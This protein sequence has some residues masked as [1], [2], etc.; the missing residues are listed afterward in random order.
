VGNRLALHSTSIGKA[1]LA[2]LLPA[3][4]ATLLAPEAL[5]RRTARTLT[6]VRELEAELAAIRGQGYAIDDEENEEQIRCVGAAI[7][8]RRGHVI[9]G[10]SLSAPAFAMPVTMAHLLGPSVLA[11]ARELSI[12]LGARQDVLPAPY[13]PDRSAGSGESAADALFG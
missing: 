4:R 13:A 5:V 7:F 10:M 12:S 9:G 2:Y 11:A 1:I 6:T 3:E 8:D